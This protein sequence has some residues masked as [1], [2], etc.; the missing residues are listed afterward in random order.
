[1]ESH[2]PPV[3]TQ[4]DPIRR[5]RS[6][7]VGQDVTPA[8][9]DR[10]RTAAR[11]RASQ[12]QGRYPTSRLR[13][14]FAGAAGS[15]ALVALVTALFVFGDGRL[16]SGVSV[17]QRAR[18]AQAHARVP[19]MLTHER[20]VETYW[21][22]EAP[23]PGWARSFALTGTV[24]TETWRTYDRTATRL[25][26]WVRDEDGTRRLPLTLITSGDTTTRVTTD[27]ASVSVMQ[28]VGAKTATAKPA[29][30]SIHKAISMPALTDCALC[31]A[32][33]AS[34]SAVDAFDASVSVPQVL[35]SLGLLTNAG[36]TEYRGSPAWVL[37]SSGTTV[38]AGDADGADPQL[39]KWS[40]EM[41]VDVDTYELLGARNRSWTRDEVDSL[42]L[43]H[44]WTLDLVTAEAVAT[45]TVPAGWFDPSL[46][47][48]RNADYQ[49]LVAVERADSYGLVPLYWFGDEF[50]LAGSGVPAV[51]AEPWFDVASY[52]GDPFGAETGADA[53]SV[54][55][56]RRLRGS[57]DYQLETGERITV[58][59]LPRMRP[60]ALISMLDLGRNQRAKVVRMDSGTVT[61]VQGT[62]YSPFASPREVWKTQE[63]YVHLGDSTIALRDLPP[64]ATNAL[65]RDD[66]ALASLIS[67]LRRIN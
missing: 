50:E 32:V 66:E 37:R 33:T 22:R 18:A 65:G 6:G 31:H 7:F 48:A 43:A 28:W 27:G 29:A 59:T 67:R 14:L 5:L 3:P 13:P 52:V 39:M 51:L 49:A 2:H 4:P 23:N 8:V 40:L 25:E 47:P 34:G 61:V 64:A 44:E 53:A 21:E 24:E 63:I 9:L 54:A 56:A 17:L 60:T 58:A 15:V 1:M 20:I 35:L 36:K 16:P 57:A 45:D 11:R 46:V 62:G 42:S 10:V 38:Q 19:G 55:G 30:F 41:Y 26:Q 12:P